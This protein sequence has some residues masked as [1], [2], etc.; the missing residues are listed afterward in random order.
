MRSPHSGNGGART[1]NT[2]SL[3]KLPAELR[4]TLFTHFLGPIR[5]LAVSDGKGNLESVILLGSKMENNPDAPFARC[6]DVSD[7][8]WQ[9]QI[10]EVPS[11]NVAVLLLSKSTY[12]EV[13]HAGWVGSTKYFIES[14]YQVGLHS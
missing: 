14:R 11:P 10:D 5:P 13:L 6:F 3:M 8:Y 4:Q 2:L 9:A 12:K 7:K 1:A